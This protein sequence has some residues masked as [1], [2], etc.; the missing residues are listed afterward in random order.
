[1]LSGVFFRQ[2]LSQVST[3]ERTEINNMKQRVFLIVFFA[4]TASVAYGA[5][6]TGARNCKACKNCRYCKHCNNGGRC[7]VCSSR[8]QDDKGNVYQLGAIGGGM[9]L[10]YLLGKRKK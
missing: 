3:C 8:K 5:T 2:P 1:M 4:L 6:C 7:G 9:A 10:F